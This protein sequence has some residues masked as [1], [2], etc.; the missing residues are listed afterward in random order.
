MKVCIPVAEYCGLESP[1]YGH[2][3]SAPTFVLVDSET[4]SVESLGNRDQTHVHGQCSPVKALAG[5]RPD[6][7]VVSGIG[8]GALIGLREAGIRVYR[9]TGETVAEVVSLLKKGDL[10]EIDREHTCLGHGEGSG[11]HHTHS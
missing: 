7:V 8:A 6:A 10:K 11:C 9:A 1:V 3:G 2:F 5:A 4:M